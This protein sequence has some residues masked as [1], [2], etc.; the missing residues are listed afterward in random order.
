[1]IGVVWRRFII[2]VVIVGR[3]I[4]V[5]FVVD[6]VIG[7]IVVGVVVLLIGFGLVRRRVG[8]RVWIDLLLLLGEG[9]RKIA[10]FCG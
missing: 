6:V 10:G 8:S 7:R 3:I 4:I 5:W 9:V 2:I 1:L